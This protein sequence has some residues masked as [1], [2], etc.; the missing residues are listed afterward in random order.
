MLRSNYKNWS[1]KRR[2]HKTTSHY[3]LLVHFETPCLQFHRVSLEN[4]TKTCW[5]FS[6]LYSPLDLLM[7]KCPM[8]QT[9]GLKNCLWHQS[10]L[11][12]LWGFEG[13]LNTHGSSD[14]RKLPGQSFLC[15]MCNFW[16]IFDCQI[17]LV[18][19]IEFNETWIHNPFRTKLAQVNEWVERQEWI[20]TY[21]I[22]ASRWRQG[23]CAY[24]FPKSCLDYHLHCL[25]TERN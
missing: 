19:I 9:T 25:M 21:P 8:I 14:A 4:M 5:C 6:N 17:E 24:F 3:L 13:D 11:S 22:R 16:D 18:K 10:V 20:V 12:Y 1:T 15:L 23:A 7:N 2:K